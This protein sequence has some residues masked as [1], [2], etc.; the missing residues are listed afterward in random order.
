MKLLIIAMLCLMVLF[1]S[2]SESGRSNL[3]PTADI[4]GEVM[5]TVIA[6]ELPAAGPSQP[7]W[8]VNPAT[9]GEEF[10]LRKVQRGG[11]LGVTCVS[12]PYCPDCGSTANVCRVTKEFFPGITGLLAKKVMIDKCRRAHALDYCGGSYKCV[13]QKGWTLRDGDKHRAKYGGGCYK[14]CDK[15]VICYPDS[16]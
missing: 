5:A 3:S 14:Q 7:E 16:R 12:S 11:V 1:T 6:S 9:T 13:R 8:I 10:Y 4:D 2:R 15:S